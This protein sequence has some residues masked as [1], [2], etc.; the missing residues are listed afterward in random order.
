MSIHF[1]TAF[2]NI[3][4]SPFQA[5]AAIF[6]LTLTFFVITTLAVLVYSSDKVLEYFETR[7]QVIAFLKKDAKPEQISVLQSKLTSDTRV[8]EVKFVSKEDALS[9]HKEA[10]SDN[11]LLSEL[12]SPAIFPASLEFSLANISYAEAII[13]EIKKETVVDQVGFT[14]NLGGEANI[15]STVKRLKTI[16]WY[17]RLGGGLF[18]GLLLA[19]SVLVLLVVI[20]MR[21][22]VR[23]EEVEILGLIGATSS[24]IRNPVIIEALVYSLTGVFVGWI[25]SLI[26]TLYVTPTIISYFKEIPV[27]PQNTT[28]LLSLF[29]LIFVSEAVI[30]AFLALVGSLFAISR[31][32]K[33]K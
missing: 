24:F 2:S 6:T 32:R 14:A 9:I 22:L 17:L 18:V 21:L 7:P 4:R 26:V 3:R 5:I 30:G 23:R 1:K 13:S 10:T 20:S 31:S 28:G 29:G 8:K 15:D 16:T 25:L 11:P 33:T 19:T 12:V 27:L